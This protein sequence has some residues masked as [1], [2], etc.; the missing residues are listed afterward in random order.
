MSL[1]L[2]FLAVGYANNLIF[3]FFFMLISVALTG[4]VVTNRNVKKINFVELQNLFIFAQEQSKI[5]VYLKNSSLINS[6]ELEIFFEKF[7]AKAVLFSIS[8]NTEI[9][10]GIPFEF[11][12]RGRITLPRLIV[13]STFP[14]GLLRAWRNFR[15][16]EANLIV[17]PARIGQKEFPQ[18]LMNGAKLLSTG[19][20]RDHRIYRSGDSVRRIDWKASARRRE[21]LIKSYEEPEKPTLHFFWEQTEHLLDFE[22]RVSQLTVWVDQAEQ[23]QCEYSL[24]MGSQHIIQ[25]RGR[26]HWHNCLE[27]L[28]L[29]NAEAMK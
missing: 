2:F 19:I 26:E 9:T 13:Q 23:L 25:G 5:P 7:K 21:L 4:M 8:A 6:L 18:I 27:L 11:S 24:H 14:F 3:I 12:R 20:F 29:V 16:S 10:I 22:E 17:Y 28:A 1:V 15:V